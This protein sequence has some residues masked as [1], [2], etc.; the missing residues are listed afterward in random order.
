M[1]KFSVVCEV[2]FIVPSS[3]AQ[4]IF[5]HLN[6]RTKDG[7]EEPLHEDLGKDNSTETLTLADCL[8]YDFYCIVTHRFLKRQ[9]YEDIQ[10]YYRLNL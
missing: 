7:K 5:L 3:E 8:L 1:F 9:K 4:H 2:N 10:L 6:W